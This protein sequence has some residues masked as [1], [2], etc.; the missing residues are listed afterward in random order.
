[1]DSHKRSLFAQ[2]PALLQS[3]V[4]S[5]MHPVRKNE[6][7]HIGIV[8]DEPIRLEGLASIFDHPAIEGQAQLLPVKGSLEELLARSTLD[9]MVVDL[10]S[11]SGGLETLKAIRRARPSVKLIVIGPDGNDELVMESIMA[12]ARAYL[13]LTASPATVR[14][15]IRE[16]TSGSIWAPRRLLSSLID[17][18]LNVSDTS[19]ANARPHL[20][21][22][23]RQVL[24]L[25][26]LARSNR[27]IARQLGIEERTVKSHV[28]RL[29][30]KT[31]VENRIEL[32]M[33]ALSQS[34]LPNPGIKP[35]RRIGAPRSPMT[36]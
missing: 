11:S 23:E 35:P 24:E 26:L 20:T 16:V 29:M 25:I 12:G 10:H 2:G 17:K 4:G 32:S 18:L 27:E 8:S 21:D 3:D 6:A 15:A 31:G 9:Y 1:M 13:D 14:M 7:I 33:R 36:G 28:S 19:L 30:R 5:K 34:L 22:R